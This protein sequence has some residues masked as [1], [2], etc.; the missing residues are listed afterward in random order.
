MTWLKRLV[1]TPKPKRRPIP[2][3]ELPEPA[4]QLYAVH[5]PQRGYF[6]PGGVVW[7]TTDRELA[8]AQADTCERNNGNYD[9]RVVPLNRVRRGVGPSEVK[10]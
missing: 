5:S 7:N 8:D 6:A 10:R 1:R 2:F 3:P 4:A 9:W